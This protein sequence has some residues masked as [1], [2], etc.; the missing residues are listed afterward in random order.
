MNIDAIW[1]ARL[2]V[3]GL[4][5]AG[6]TLG[7]AGCSREDNASSTSPVRAQPPA[8][9][10]GAKPVPAGSVVDVDAA[11]AQRLVAEKKV[12]VL[13]VRTPEEYAAGHIAGAINLNV[14]DPDF[15]TRASALAADAT[16]LVHCAAG[17]PG[18]RSRQ[19]VAILKD[20]GLSHLVHLNG[21]YGAWLAAK[22]GGPAGESSR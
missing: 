12:T 3:V 2:L 14:R 13:D 21:G 19:A 8:P 5:L 18:G 17:T 4:A 11:A 9:I 15:K 10:A 20:L 7:A 16:Y 6:S 22:G 1:L